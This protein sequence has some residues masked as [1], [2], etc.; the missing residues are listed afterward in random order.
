MVLSHLE[1]LTDEA[2]R[3]AVRRFR[4]QMQNAAYKQ[5]KAF[6][7][8]QIGSVSAITEIGLALYVQTELMTFFAEVVEPMASTSDGLA[9]VKH[10]ARSCGG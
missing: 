3:E 2:R 9:W 4:K 1:K 6:A 7:E 8:R 10:C 5:A